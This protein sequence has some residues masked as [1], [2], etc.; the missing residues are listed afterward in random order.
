MFGALSRGLHAR[1][2]RSRGSST[3]HRCARE[4]ER[5][6]GD[7]CVAVDVMW[8]RCCC[9]CGPR[10]AP[11]RVARSCNCNR[12]VPHPPQNFLFNTCYPVGPL[13][14]AIFCTVLTAIVVMSDEHS[15]W[16]AGPVAELVWNIA[17]WFP[18]PGK[19]P[20]M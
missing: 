6:T 9:C 8:P 15:W 1:L 7:T 12:G 19:L 16:R 4:L 14:L 10:E 18:W 2:R 5:S 20:R 17:M 3:G 11:A 13:F